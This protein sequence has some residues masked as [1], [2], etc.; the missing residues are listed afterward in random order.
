MPVPVDKSEEVECSSCS[1][2]VYKRKK[3][4]VEIMTI[5]LMKAKTQAV[6]IRVWNT[7]M[8]K[9]TAVCS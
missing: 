5:V 3:Q 7:A 8:I 4:V 2:G 1:A 6:Q 9:K